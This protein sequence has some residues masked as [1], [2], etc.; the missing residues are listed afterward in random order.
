MLI[1]ALVLV[2][3]P[4]FESVGK[5]L[6]Q[7]LKRV[8]D[9]VGAVATGITD[10]VL[11]H[12]V[13]LLLDL[14][15][16]ASRDAPRGVSARCRRALIRRVDL[17]AAR[18]RLPRSLLKT[19]ER[20]VEKVSAGRRPEFQCAASGF[21]GFRDGLGD[22]GVPRVDFKTREQLVYGRPDVRGAGGER[23]DTDYGGVAVA[24]APGQGFGR[25]LAADDPR[26]HDGVPPFRFGSLSGSGRWP[27][28]HSRS[29]S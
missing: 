17:R 26:F 14:G 19:R 3:L 23:G 29:I 5:I 27:S 25:F 10:G 11:L 28:A 20:R 12:G 18:A 22:S 24:H 1:P 6:D 8:G 21:A 16:L 13:Y 9:L 2:A 15:V 7:V 4:A